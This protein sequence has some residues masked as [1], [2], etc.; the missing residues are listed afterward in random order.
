MANPIKPLANSP[1]WPP[2]PSAQQAASP[3]PQ[4]TNVK[5][6]PPAVSNTQDNYTHHSSP[7]PGNVQTPYSQT[8]P[9][10]AS[11]KITKMPDVPMHKVK[12]SEPVG[13]P[14]NRNPY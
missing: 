1:I 13:R 9:Q 7:T 5:N 3:G 12:H 2:N 11:K 8:V 4:P 6:A 14:K 10:N